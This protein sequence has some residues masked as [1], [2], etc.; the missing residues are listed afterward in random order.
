MNRLVLIGNGY[1]LAAGLETSYENFIVD[2]FKLLILTATQTQDFK[3]DDICKIEVR[4]TDIILDPNNIE[5]EVSLQPDKISD[6]MKRIS[7]L[8][9]LFK[10]ISLNIV[11]YSDADEKKTIFTITIKSTFF[12][13]LI[14]DFNWRDIEQFYFNELIKIYNSEYF[15]NGESRSV[16]FE[17]I[18]KQEK[19][20]YELLTLNNEFEVIKL[21]L[22]EYLRRVTIKYN[23]IENKGHPP[24]FVGKLFEP[25]SIADYEKMFQGTLTYLDN[26][27]EYSKREIALVRILNFNYTTLLE[28]HLKPNQ[29]NKNPMLS[30]HQIHGTVDN[31][32][33]IIFGYGDDTHPM[34]SKLELTGNDEYLKHLK[35]FYYPLSENYLNLMNFI[36]FDQFE[37]QIV[38]HSL[39]LSDRVLLKSIF[40]HKNCRCITLKHRGRN[41]EKELM[42]SKYM[43]LSRHFD[44]KVAMRKKVKPFNV[45]DWLH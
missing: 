12:K 37:V 31:P 24:S 15:E 33:E 11:G 8:D 26:K 3:G 28:N 25:L 45:G 20:D 23:K 1:D 9:D 38:G 4:R 43:A 41:N 10:Y 40:E 5:R 22:A 27:E 17:D 36:E 30:V 19:I 6:K 34:Y 21:K 42:S 7:S 16:A 18:A 29:V 2:Y 44:D 35:S 32:K 13:Q 14:G 39:G